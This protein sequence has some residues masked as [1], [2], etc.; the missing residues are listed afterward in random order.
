MAKI[1][2]RAWSDGQPTPAASDRALINQGLEVLTALL[3]LVA[4]ASGCSA[5][6]LHTYYREALGHLV[7]WPA[8]CQIHDEATKANK[9]PVGSLGQQP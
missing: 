2:E 6:W 9:R 7:I 1:P 5:S 4:V 8:L 3:V